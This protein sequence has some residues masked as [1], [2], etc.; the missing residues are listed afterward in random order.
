[1]LSTL[2]NPLAIILSLST[3]SGVLIH[4]MHL[5]SAATAM[6]MPIASY[7]TNKTA[8]LDS[9]SH[10]HVERSSFSQLT[11]GLSRHFEMQPR[12]A[13]DK[14]HLLQKYAARGHHAFDNYYLPIV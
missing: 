7:D 6:T 3:A 1:M 4:D 11:G 14:K 12:T 9:A 10:T 2:L 5:D 8:G 13:S